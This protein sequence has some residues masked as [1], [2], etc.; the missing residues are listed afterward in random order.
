MIGMTTLAPKKLLALST[1]FALFAITACRPEP[2]AQPV[3]PQQQQPQ[4]QQWQPQGAWPQQQ[5]QPQQPQQLGWLPPASANLAQPDALSIALTDRINAYRVSRGLPSI[6]RS[7]ALGIVATNHA[8]DLAKNYR[9]GGD[10]CNLHSWSQSNVWSGCC[11]TPDHAQAKCMWQKPRELTG[12]PAQG[13]E[14]SA[15]STGTLDPDGALQIWQGSPGHHAV[16]LSQ[17]EWGSSPWRSIG[18]AIYGGFAVAWFAHEPD[19]AGGY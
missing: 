14:I 17:G 3:A 5:Q 4:Q 18:A 15:M 6:P 8:R 16:I 10:S 9:G 2:S 19:G 12:F 11:Y 13:Y 1:L 7:R